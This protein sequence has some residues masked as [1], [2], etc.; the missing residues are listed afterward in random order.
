MIPHARDLSPVRTVESGTPEAMV[1]RLRGVAAA[2]LPRMYSPGAQRYVFTVR[3][4]DG[5]LRPAGV[6]SRYTAITL[7]GLAADGLDKWTLPFEAKALARALVKD[8]PDNRNLGDAA[9]V[10]WA[11]RAVGVETELAWRHVAGL[12]AR[13]PNHPT[14]EIAWALAAAVMDPQVSG[15]DLQRGLTASLLMAW[16]S[17]SSLFAHAATDHSARAHVTCFADQ[18]YPI[19]ALSR[20]AAL[21]G[22]LTALDAA[23]RCARRVCALQGSAGQWWWHYDHRTGDI[24]EGYPVYA[25]HQDAMAPMAL[26][27]VQDAGGGRFDDRIETGL[28]WLEHAPELG[29]ASLIDDAAQMVWRKVARREPL[30]ATRF[31]QAACTALHPRLRAPGAD[32]LFPAVAIDYEDRPY[33]WGWF[34]YAWAAAQERRA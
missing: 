15:S 13:R 2:A 3:R 24:I 18:V 31:V 30:K 6:S 27:A 17:G 7:I 21:Q 23:A 28:R 22:D 19:F 12:L 26:R 8:L 1:Q 29:D 34:L 4:E 25:I 16:N 9:L 11:A 33:H 14:V 20:L 32:T 10:A 5:F